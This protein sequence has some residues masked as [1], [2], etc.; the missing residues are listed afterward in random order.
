MSWVVTIIQAKYHSKS[1]AGTDQEEILHF[2]DCLNRLKND[3]FKQ[4]KVLSEIT[5]SIDFKN[6][7]FQLLFLCLGKIEGQAKI[8]TEQELSY[9]EDLLNR[10]SIEYLDENQITEEFRSVATIGKRFEAIQGTIYSSPIS[11]EKARTPI[12]KLETEDGSSYILITEA[13]HL[14]QFYNQKSVKDNLFSLNIRNYL[15]NN[16]NNQG[17]IETAKKILESFSLLIM[18]F[19]VWPKK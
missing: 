4:N 8:Q 3:D 6:D 11:G 12:I 15:G 18:G 1:S 19:P 10:I 14:V 5:D 7:E 2:Q 9:E 16:K 13:T 17:I